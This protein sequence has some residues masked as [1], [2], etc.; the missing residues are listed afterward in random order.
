MRAHSGEIVGVVALI[1]LAGVA[2]RIHLLL[3]ERQ[4]IQNIP[5]GYNK[6]GSKNSFGLDDFGP[7]NNPYEYLLRDH[8][9]RR[10]EGAIFLM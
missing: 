7:Q 5:L 10:R 9:L 6:S 3:R 2:K 1:V 4:S 8:D